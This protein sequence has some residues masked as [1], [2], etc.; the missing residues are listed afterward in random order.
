MERE[1]LLSYILDSYPY[2]ILFADCDHIIRYMNKRAQYHYYRERGYRDLIGKSLF[3][4]HQNAKSEEIIRE[5][6][7][8]LKNH[9]NEAFLHVNVR[10]ERVYIVPVRDENGELIG[11]FERFEMNQQK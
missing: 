10:N 1:K 3:D 2:P 5:T 7:E 8:R 11:Y 4:C 6:V 9:G